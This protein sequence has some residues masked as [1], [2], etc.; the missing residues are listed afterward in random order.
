M[1][2]PDA[3][4][5]DGQPN[6]VQMGDPAHAFLMDDIEYQ[7]TGE[8]RC[9]DR[10]WCHVWIGEKATPDNK[11]FEHREWYWASNVNGEPLQPW[12]PMKLVLNRLDNNRTLLGTAD[13]HFYNYRR[14]PL[15]I[16]E[17]DFTM[18]ECYRALG[19]EEKYNLGVISFTVANDKKY[20]VIENLSYLQ[21]S[22][23]QTL[24][25]SLGVRPS[26]ISN[27]IV[28]ERANHSDIIV[29]LTLLDAPPRLGPVEDPIQETSLI[30]LIDRLGG[31]IDSNDLAFRAKQKNREVKLRA[32]PNSLNVIHTSLD[33]RYRTTGPTITGL[34]IGLLVVGLLLGAVGGFFAFR[35]LAK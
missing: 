9:R 28:D 18:A 2:G 15:T 6:L 23:W 8:K 3:V 11:G 7:Y 26:R 29:T 31:L 27:I 14:N 35:A 33:Q 17:V 30:K 19:P 16:F 13:F 4:A 24:T 12:V 20:P 22:I 1:N 34:W 21:F 25:F 5:V 32:R 10:V